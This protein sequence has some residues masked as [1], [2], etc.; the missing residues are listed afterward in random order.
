VLKRRVFNLIVFIV[1]IIVGIAILKANK[2][3]SHSPE[4]VITSAEKPIS[5]L[6]PREAKYYKVI[7]E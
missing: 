4:T 1:I 7:E 3:K 2:P 5:N 6:N